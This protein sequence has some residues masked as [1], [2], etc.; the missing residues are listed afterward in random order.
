MN[1]LPSDFVVTTEHQRFAEFCDACRQYRYIG[2]CYG[3]PGVGKTLSARLYANA[4]LLETWL[5]SHSMLIPEGATVPDHAT[6][7]YTPEVVNTPRHIEHSIQTKRHQLRL[8]AVE[9]WL[10]KQQCLY[11]A[12]KREEALLP[13]RR[14]E[15]PTRRNGNVVQIYEVAARP[16]ADIAKTYAEQG[17]TMPDPTNLIIIDE[18]DRLK[19]A[20]LEQ[21]RDIF[22]HSDL[23]M[24]LIGMPGLE[25]RLSR[26]PQFY[27]RVGFVHAF[28]PLSTPQV[29]TLLGRKGSPSGVILPE[30]GVTDE[31]TVAAII[32]VTGGNF[33]LLH[34]LLTQIARI[35]EINALLKV[36]QEV[37]EA[38]REALVIGAT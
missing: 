33:R 38:A 15:S 10:E 29:R 18:A 14:L 8:L 34:R 31:A 5:S 6:V 37:V 4:V 26:Y 20:S 13:P 23:G 1:S 12:R 28:R 7:F 25:K 30:D 21:V 17:A 27:S 11:Q 22:D 24:V 2:L 35:V 16:G 32:R 3:A 19:T 36:T 9:A